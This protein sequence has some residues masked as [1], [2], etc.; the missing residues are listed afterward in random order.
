MRRRSIL[1]GSTGVLLFG[2]LAEAKTKPILANAHH[3]N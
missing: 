3:T 1:A 2:R